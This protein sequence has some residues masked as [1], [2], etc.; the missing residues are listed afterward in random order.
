MKFANI[1]FQQ[2]TGEDSSIL[3]YSIPENLKISTGQSVQVPIRGKNISGIVWHI[4]NDTPSF[5]TR[6]IQEINYDQP[7]LSADQIELINWMH[8][9][10]FCP[11][12]KI[13]KLFIPTKILQNKKLRAKAQADEQI[14]RSKILRLTPAQEEAVR[15]IKA[16]SLNK[17]LIHGVTGSGKTEI[18][19]SLAD[20]YIQQ[21][22]QVLILVPEI[23][24]TPQ[25]IDY[26]QKSL[27]IKASVIHSKISES[28]RH[29]SWMKIWQNESKLIIGSRSSIFAPFQSLGLIIVDEEHEPSYKQEQS[30]RY[31]IHAIIDKMLELSKNTEFKVVFGSAT[32]SIESAEKLKDSTI[33]INE[34]I[35]RSVMPEIEVVDMREE[36]KKQNYS[37]FSD[38][39]QEELQK[40]IADGKQA[41]LF[42]NRRGSASSVVCRDCGHSEKC[43]AC[44]TTMTYHKNPLSQD[45]LICHH[46]GKISKPPINC[47]NCQGHNIR[48]LGIGTQRIESE[49]LKDFPGIK[50]L[51]ADKDTTSG[52]N[53]FEKIYRSF[54]N[55]EA[56]ILIGTQMIAKGL[57]LPSVNLVGVILADIGLN[58]PDFRASERN[59][60]L[61]T[62]VSGRTGRSKE[63]GKVIIQTYNPDH[64]ALLCSSEQNYDKFFNYERTQ[65]KILHNPP[66]G[67]LAKILIEDKSATKCLEKAEQM[68]KLLWR[69]T[70]EANL[71]EDLEINYYPAY[72][73]KLRGKY[74]Y[75]ILIKSKN[76][77]TPPHIIL[78]KLPKADI[79]SPNI[80][81]D[82]DPITTT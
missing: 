22:Q 59:F 7:L 32:P 80:K 2:K 8:Q 58:T 10:Y 38:R 26:F 52:K 72:L 56:Q 77:S 39:L 11:L 82:I 81:I 21:G 40:V 51:R 14:I 54:K 65:R 33:R 46:C 62:Q 12:N 6:P 1:L 67:K 66:F 20:H 31:S 5:K 53:D 55:Q 61:M 63:K 68:E 78:E 29:K 76:D 60:Q 49:I 73:S 48:F 44:E 37:I 47:P 28:E 50:V 24:L 43:P 17:F 79:M 30:P 34:R 41:I 69:I 42:L 74:R 70:R 45:R 16:Q 18:Y 27:G 15:S 9:Y 13:L 36:F 75:I 57:H 35:G 4:H 23:S 19:K 25:N 64:L 71:S 3:T